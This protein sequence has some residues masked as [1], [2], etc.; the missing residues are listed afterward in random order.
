MVVAAVLTSMTVGA[1]QVQVPD[2]LAQRVLAC[3]ACHGKRLT[4]TLPGIP[5]LVGLP[6]DYLNSQFGA[7]KNGARKAHAPYC[8]AQISQQL[9]PEDIGAISTWLASQAV[10]DDM[11]PAPAASIKLPIRCSSVPQ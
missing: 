5:S 11:S 1:Q 8:M 2:T 7:W 3:A 6:R 9:E 10:P 4:G